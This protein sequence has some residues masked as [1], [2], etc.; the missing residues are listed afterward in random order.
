MQSKSIARMPHFPYGTQSP[1]SPNYSTETQSRPGNSFSDAM[2][3]AIG[4]FVNMSLQVQSTPVA[5]HPSSVFSPPIQ[6]RDVPLGKR[7]LDVC[8]IALG[9]PFIGPLMLGVAIYIKLVSR[10]PILFVQSRVGH[11]GQDF[12]IYKF[13]TMHVPHISRANT[14]RDYVASC[15]GSDKPLKKP[16]HQKDLIFGGRL[17]RGLAIDELPQLLNVLQGNMSLVGPRPDLLRLEDYE[18]WQTRRFEV[19]PGITGLW[20]ISGK[21]RLTF[22]QMIE[23]DINYVDSM[24]RFQD[25]QI[26][27]RTLF[28]ILFERN[29]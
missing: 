27:A 4:T 14:H 2:A 8:A 18:P 16:E 3:S 12:L 22:E 6:K 11:G 5:G 19:L 20:Q 21:N 25:L 1:H 24:S 28:V 29:E 26:L 9:M 7:A 17:L 23:L 10:G 13:R 15:R